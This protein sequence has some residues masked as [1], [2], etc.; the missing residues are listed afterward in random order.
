M[1]QGSYYYK[2]CVNAQTASGRGVTLAAGL[3]GFGAPEIRRNEAHAS[4]NLIEAIESIGEKVGS[5][6]VADPACFR[7]FATFGS[8]ELVL[9]DLP[10]GG[11]AQFFAGAAWSRDSRFDPFHRRWP[12]ITD[13]ATFDK[14]AK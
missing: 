4:L 9:L 3:T 10:A 6:L 13:E 8:D 14:I 12:R 5:S 2:A 11:S 7:G 1:K